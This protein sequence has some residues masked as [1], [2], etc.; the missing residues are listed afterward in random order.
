MK[1]EHQT[2]RIKGLEQ[3]LLQAFPETPIGTTCEGRRLT[4]HWTD[5]PS[6]SQVLCRVRGQAIDLG[7]EPATERRLS[8]A[9]VRI[10]VLAAELALRTPVPLPG[11]A[12][13]LPVHQVLERVANPAAHGWLLTWFDHFSTVPEAVRSPRNVL[14]ADF[15][16]IMTWPSQDELRRLQEKTAARTDRDIPASTRALN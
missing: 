7:F 12:G 1:P 16:Q 13:S 6:A 10:G 15:R 8:A 3:L 2:G 4:F 14:E 9:A 11:I 5:G